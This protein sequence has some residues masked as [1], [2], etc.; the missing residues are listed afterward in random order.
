MWW[1]RDERYQAVVVVMKDG[2]FDCGSEKARYGLAS[3]RGPLAVVVCRVGIVVIEKES[4]RPGPDVMVLVAS[5]KWPRVLRAGLCRAPHR[6]C[7]RKAS[8]EYGIDTVHA[9]P[10]P[11]HGTGREGIA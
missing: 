6:Y 1:R 2:I 11:R 9:S 10:N 4:G 8:T 3:T 7:I 5:G